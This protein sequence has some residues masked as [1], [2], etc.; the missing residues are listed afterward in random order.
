MR[1]VSLLVTLLIFSGTCVA[2][3]AYKLETVAEG[4]NFP[5]SIA[6]LPSGGYLVAIRSGEVRPCTM[7]AK[8]SFNPTAHYS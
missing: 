5:W 3:A 8:C 7:A 1:L 4:L 6:F 2:K